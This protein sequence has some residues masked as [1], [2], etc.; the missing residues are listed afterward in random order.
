[1]KRIA[2]VLLVALAG[3]DQGGVEMKNASVGEV[4]EAVRKERVDDR[5]IDPGKWEQTVTLVSVDAPGMPDE[6]R[7]AMQRAMKQAQVHSVCLTP[8]EAKSPREDFFTGKDQNC[9]YEHFK[10]GKGKIDLKLKCDHPNAQQTME[11]AGAYAPRHY[12]MTMTATN[13]GSSPQEHMV[14]KMKVDARH[15]GQCTGSEEA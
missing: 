4:A 3:C 9:R 6:V 7:N 15:V 12:T 11:L 1:M 8:E 10:W 13:E 14:M 2:V 5:F